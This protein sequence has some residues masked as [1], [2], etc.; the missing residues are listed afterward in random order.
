MSCPSQRVTDLPEL[1]A[2]KALLTSKY[3]KDYAF[4]ASDD[5]YAYKFQ[6]NENLKQCVLQPARTPQAH[7]QT[8]CD[9]TL[10][11]EFSVPRA[12]VHIGSKLPEKAIE[13]NKIHHLTVPLRS[14]DDESK[15]SGI[16]RC[17]ARGSG[18]AGVC[19]TPGGRVCSA[20]VPAAAWHPP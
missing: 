9:S 10:L 1:A 7:P 3:G 8:T 15:E 11:V 17:R 14:P 13:G 20:C 4:E 19:K 5:R 6:V 16:L 2:I 12:H 18:H